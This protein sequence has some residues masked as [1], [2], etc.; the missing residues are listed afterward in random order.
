[1][2]DEAS[3]P[4]FEDLLEYLKQSR[5]F[6]FTGYKRASLRRRIDK[7]MRA[8]GIDSYTDYVEFLE[9]HPDE[10]VRLFNAILI[11]VTAFFR[12]PGAWS[13]LREELLPQRL[14]ALGPDR[15][16]RVWSAGCASG[17]EAYTVAMT[18]ADLLGPEEFIKR[19][20]IYGTDVDEEALQTARQA[21]Y[22]DRDI[23]SVP[24]DYRERYFERVGDRNVFRADLRRSIIFGRLDVLRDAPISRLELLMCRNTLMYFNAETQ[25]QV[26]GRFHF[27]LNDT[28]VL[29]L[30][31]AE[32]LLSHSALFESIERKQR[33]FRK[34][35]NRNGRDRGNADRTAA[36]NTAPQGMHPTDALPAGAFATL[37]IAA[38]LFDD[39]A[40]LVEVNDQ[41]RHLLNM[42]ETDR[43]V[44]LQ[45]LDISY[46]PVD[47]RTPVI[48]ALS[49][50][51]PAIIR[52]VEWPTSDGHAREL[53][54]E[55]IPVRGSAS[56]TGVALFFHDRTEQRELEERLELSTL[57]LE[58]AYQE[59]QSTN[60]EL[61]TTNEELQS[62]IEE[63]ETT[64]E[65]LQSTNEELETMNEEL[66]STNDEL[67]TVNEELRIRGDEVD[68][69][70]HFLQAI[71]TS[72]RGGV[73]VLDSQRN[74]LVWNSQAADLW[75]L[76]EEEVTGQDFLEI[77]IGLPTKRLRDALTATLEGNAQYEE[78]EL[79]AITRRGRS[80]RCK[81][82]ITPLHSR[83]AADGA[84][85]VM[86]I[87]P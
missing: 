17:E 62:T 14:A 26:I 61:E 11:N 39:T 18:L 84:I 75:G 70:N 68:Q 55:V 44:L 60:E 38:L 53:E 35:A 16:I 20:K 69:L 33:I 21:T 42:G 81:V 87:V 27:A 36:R 74:V 85:L 41:A 25:A 77:D 48:Q 2:P 78:I 3:P 7:Q 28:G 22:D 79:D 8:T 52:G 76:R 51:R 59:V 12:D 19:V 71:L 43:G 57:E 4:E 31:R 34:L 37:P 73:V 86:E 72:F 1:M 23:A 10:F 45:D 47:L 58:Q 30:G 24:D 54:V 50:L 67:H 80:V 64:N 65:E 46:R 32:T 29:M 82:S 63:L 66:Q 9:V 5:G 49:D 15:P 6:D 83:G 40:T 13:Y 56:A